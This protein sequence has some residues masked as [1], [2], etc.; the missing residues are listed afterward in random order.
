MTFLKRAWNKL[1]LRL[2][3]LVLLFSILP[4]ILLGVFAFNRSQN[5]LEHQQFDHLNA[6]AMLKGEEFNRW[7][8]NNVQQLNSLAQRPLVREYAAVL[9]SGETAVADAQL[10]HD[11]LLTNHLIPKLAN[12]DGF[13]ELFLLDTNGRIVISTDESSEGVFR[14]SEPYF[15]E[16]QQGAYVQNAYIAPSGQP[17]MTIGTPVRNNEG[18]VVAVLA[19]HLDLTELSDIAWQTNNLTDSEDTYFVDKFNFFVTDPRFGQNYALQETIHTEGAARCLQQES[20][21]GV[22]EDYRGVVV[23]GAYRWLPQRELCVISEI[24]QAEALAAINNLRHSLLVV[25]ALVIGGAAL[26]GIFFTRSITTPLHRLTNG[27]ERIGRGDLDHQ[28]P[29]YGQDEIGQLTASFNRM[30]RELRQSIGETIQGQR[31]ISALGQAAQAAQRARTPQEVYKIIG[32]EMARLDF[33]VV[34]LLFTEDGKY[35]HV[36][37]MSYD[38]SLVRVAEKLTGLSVDNYDFLMSPGGYFEQ[39]LTDRKTIFIS[40]AGEFI[41]EALPKP[42][43]FLANQVA[44]LFGMKQCI[45]APLVVE[46]TVL[47]A[48]N[49]IGDNLTESDVTAVSA[50]ANQTAIALQN[51]QYIAQLSQN[52][53][54]FRA[55]FEHAG[56]GIARVDMEGKPV[57]VNPALQKM[58]GYTADELQQMVF[59]E[60]THPE[61]AA[62]DMA[63]YKSLVAGERDMY[64][65]EK[66]YVRQD[67]RLV[68][69]QLTVSL[70]RDVDG[71]PLFAI[72]M[73][74]DITE[75]KQIQQAHAEQRA[76]LESIYEGADLA[77]F[78]VNVS[79]DGQF[80]FAGLNPAHE[81]LTGL[82]SVEM[83]GK[84]PHDLI[85][86]IPSEA[87]DAI[88]A[89]YARCLAA[90]KT[91]AY[92]EM[93]PMGG[94]GNM[95]ADPAQPPA[96]GRRPYLPPRWHGHVHL[97]AQTGRRT[98][99]PQRNRPE[100]TQ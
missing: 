52:E 98:A 71:D 37:H 95:V 24:D 6:V 85:P 82:N 92:E 72:G 48:L 58:L 3:F 80:H 68:W 7:V 61:D 65:I 97:R 73:V 15:L 86:Y 49:V 31:Q 93:I 53:A 9:T 38:S 4:L 89:N 87:A 5:A 11:N 13:G 60:F 79:P 30:T 46:D 70:V 78:V 32:T 39:I 27:L 21:Q 91:I 59:T 17:E 75:Q 41:A 47:G 63:L 94:A 34:V 28:I 23:L 19:G 54:R 44:G 76:F 55:I 35:L 26:A 56:I 77:I 67:G 62:N 22:Y 16:G 18:T 74:Q 40:E 25:G 83:R 29:E 20:G 8:R 57:Q 90:G 12:E 51:T 1:D 14:D 33:E 81:R 96:E 100:T 45:I 50:F 36:G 42:I 10:A 43:H 88:E 69:A 64:Q 84:T 66:R 99:A 2:T